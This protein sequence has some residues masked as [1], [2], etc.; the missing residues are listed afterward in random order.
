[1]PKCL[2]QVVE[3]ITGNERLV[4]VGDEMRHIGDQWQEVYATLANAGPAKEV[5]AHG[6]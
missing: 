1:M 3:Q 2:R 4:N 5:L 6:V